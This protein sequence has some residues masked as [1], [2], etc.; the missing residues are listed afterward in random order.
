MGW[1]TIPLETWWAMGVVEMPNPK[2]KLIFEIF[3][4]GL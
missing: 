2:K 4:F 1:P 3:G